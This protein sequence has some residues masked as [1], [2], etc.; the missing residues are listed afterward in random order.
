MRSSFCRRS[1]GWR[2]VGR[3]RR[4]GRREV[5]LHEVIADVSP[6]FDGDD[7]HGNGDDDRYGGKIRRIPLVGSA[8]LH[9]AH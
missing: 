9:A 1:M 3:R 8:L 7:E 4:G 2:H 6:R 5:A